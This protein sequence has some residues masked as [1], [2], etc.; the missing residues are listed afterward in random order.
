MW[1]LIK[2]NNKNTFRNVFIA[3]FEQVIVCWDIQAH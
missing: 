1:N 3:D 2:I